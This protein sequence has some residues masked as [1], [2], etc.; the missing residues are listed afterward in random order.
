M[1]CLEETELKE[2]F[3]NVL[4]I[5]VVASL[6]GALGHHA[7]CHAIMGWLQETDA[8]YVPILHQCKKEG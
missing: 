2:K 8:I 3:E 6:I 5:L 7:L 1:F 4:P